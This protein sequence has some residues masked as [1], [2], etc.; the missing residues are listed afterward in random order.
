MAR[1]STV[2]LA[3]LNDYLRGY[4]A[5]IQRE[6]SNARRHVFF[7]NPLQKYII[8][9]RRGNNAELEFVTECPCGYDD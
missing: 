3:Q 6:Y 2:P 9:R 4:R 5:R 8:V 1:T 7:S